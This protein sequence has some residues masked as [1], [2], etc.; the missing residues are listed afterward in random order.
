MNLSQ[1]ENR[2]LAL[3]AVCQSA[4]LVHQ[5]A[6]DGQANDF[7]LVQLCKTLFV[8]D[9]S[10][11]LD[12][13]DGKIETLTQGLNTLADVK[14][15]ALSQSNNQVMRYLITLLAIERKLN[16]QPDM[17]SVIHSRL[18]HAQRQLDYFSDDNQQ[19][20]SILS[21]IYQDTISTLPLRV[22]VN[23]NMQLLTQT[24]ISDKVRAVLFA[25]IRSAMLW[26]QLGGTKWQLLFG[27]N[28]IER[29]CKNLTKHIHY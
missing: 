28:R 15:K 5:L 14:N 6:Q 21:G 10:N 16:K 19:L 27:R 12:I 7:H 22:Q 26:R 13:Y 17:L 3:A 4:Q 23:G 1:D 8:F 2:A 20:F 11:T 29:S 18:Q 24:A 9:A 25:G